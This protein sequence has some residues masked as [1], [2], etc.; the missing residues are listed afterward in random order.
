MRQGEQQ[1]RGRK[2]V[3]DCASE[4]GE[5]RIGGKEERLQ[6]SQRRSYGLCDAFDVLT[7]C[8]LGRWVLVEC[9]AKS[10]LLDRSY[11]NVET[12]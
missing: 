8:A 9:A 7:S 3:S 6:A 10:E 12:R 4:S 1:Q 5:G 2:P 11:H